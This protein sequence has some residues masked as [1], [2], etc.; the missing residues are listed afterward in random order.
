MCAMS[1]RL[2]R[3]RATGTGL[4]A[5]AL[6][7]I[8]AVEAA[9]GQPLELA[10]KRAISDFVRGCKADGIWSSIQASCLLMGARTLSG[11]LTPL[12]GSAP[13][14]TNFV[15]ADYDRKTGLKGNGSNK[16]LNSNRRDDADA[17]NSRH[18]AI[19]VT[20]AATVGVYSQSSGLQLGITSSFVNAGASASHSAAVD[21]SLFAVSRGSSAN[22]VRRLNGGSTTVTATSSAATGTANATF[23]GRNN[24]SLF[25]D[26]R[27]AF[28][29]LGSDLNVAL[30]DQH[31]SA[32]YT[33]IGA[34][35][36]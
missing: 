13:T 11:A 9:D 17:Q 27:L 26:G 12:V 21:A 30:L 34:A 2:L 8:A 18:A 35:I 29:S 6:T 7:Y 4:D 19:F 10:V 33:A 15:S 23:F 20:T 14:N 25:S 31:V 36:V 16:L 24:S 22:Y 1:P 32:L 5:N 3:P 28:Y